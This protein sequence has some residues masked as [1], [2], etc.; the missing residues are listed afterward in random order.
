M[1]KDYLAICLLG[2]GSS[3]G[4]APDKDKAI[5]NCKRSLETDWSSI[6]DLDGKT[7]KINVYD[8]T[9]HDKLWW[10]ERGVHPDNEP[11]KSID[12]L[13]LVEVT[14]KVPKRKRR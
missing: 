12:R 3:Y 6:F 9:G 13:E 8:V 2:S 7:A 5:A 11:T 10:D 14:L 1:T 4:R